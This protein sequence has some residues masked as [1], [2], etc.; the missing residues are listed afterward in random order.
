MSQ[1]ISYGRG[2]GSGSGITTYATFA[3]LP[4]LAADG[5]AAITLDTDTL[6]IFNLG[7]LTWMPVASP[8]SVLS[9]GSP[10]NGLA[11]ALNA[12]TIDLSSSTTV[13]A[14]SAA[15]WTTFNNKQS[16]LTFGSISTTTSGVTV[17]SGSN[18]TVGPNVTVNIDTASSTTI[19]LLSAA[20]WNTFNGKQA[21]LGFTPENSANKGVANGYASLDVGGKVPASQLPS[22]VMSYQGTWNAS[23]NTPTLADGVGDAGD[24]YI[25]SV[26]GTQ[27]LGSGAITFAVSDWVIY[28]GSIWQK[29][30]NTSAV[31]SVNGFVGTVVLTQG[32]LTETTSSIL[33]ITGGTNAIWGS[34]TSIAVQQAGAATSGYLSTT[35]WN[36]FNNK[37]SSFTPGSISTTTTGV[38]VG[39]GSNSTV[40]PNVTVN[41]DT[42]SSTLTGLLSSTDWNTFN[43]TSGAA[44]TSLTGDVTGTGP[45][46]TATT[47]ANSA[48]SN[49][50]MANM[51]NNTVKANKSGSAAAPSDVALSSITESTSA[52][53]TITGTNTVIGATTIEVQQSSNVQDG[54]LSA[55]DWNTFN[56]KQDSLTP[57]S[58]STTTTGV[59]IGSGSASTIGPNVT[60]NIATASTSLTGLL[61]STDWNTF[62]NKQP[63][64]SYITALTGDVTASGPGS[65]AA[66]IAANAVTNSKFRQSAAQ[67]VV[68]N[69]TNATADVAD[70][71]A[72][73]ANQ[74][75][76]ANG[77]GTAIGFG[78]IDLA[79]SGAVGSSLLGVVNG[80]TGASSLTLN[81]VVLGNAA[82]AVNVTA[83]GGAGQVLAVPS[84][85]G[86]PAFQAL[87]VVTASRG[88]PTNISAGTAITTVA[89]VAIQTQFIQGSGGPVTMTANPS[90][91][92][93]AVI[94]QIYHIVGRSDSN[95]VTIPNGLGASLNGDA[96][97]GEDSMLS[98]MYDGTNWVEISRNF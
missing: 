83:A 91:A 86:A 18:S 62:N 81:G 31:N 53:L 21:A 87:N 39:S 49:A 94:G 70:I 67:S 47:I 74:I 65:A 79:Q 61:T 66:T 37:A 88:T 42:A 38:T 35:D 69:A 90:I 5:A 17:G 32:N 51:A 23:T 50:K 73:A 96:T 58:I 63:A 30:S 4:A 33:T 76:R 52:I 14:L 34:G 75:L 59:T 22:S 29:S 27:N 97:L 46:A 72:S 9:I 60:V 24:V 12:L 41:I 7:S 26:A 36:T 20:D 71:S 68:G 25:V 56:N 82:S 19:G 8:G 57:G 93:A 6:Y 85:G 2:S 45:G 92:A 43:T 15:D 28:D 95:T 64:G 44:V 80:G 55:L 78:S 54:Y 3:S 40:G 84:G 98:V 13:G 11:I 89:S 1:Y 16:A 77:A 48:V 10:A